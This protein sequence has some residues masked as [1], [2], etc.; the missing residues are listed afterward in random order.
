LADACGRD[1]GVTG[2][3]E[4]IEIDG[5]R[6]VIA[7]SYAASLQKARLRIAAARQNR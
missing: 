1:L 5:F 6:R 2:S 4:I 7:T 3:D